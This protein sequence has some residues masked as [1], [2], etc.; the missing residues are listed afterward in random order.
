M[1][2]ILLVRTE[3]DYEA[4]DF[5]NVFHGQ[6]VSDLIAKV[7]AGETL[8]GESGALPVTIVTIPEETLSKEL[9]DFIRHEVQD[10]DSTKHTNFYLD[11]AKV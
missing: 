1:M 11:G 8:E 2:K 6:E 5:E 9:V 3:N 10:Y 7:E 4:L